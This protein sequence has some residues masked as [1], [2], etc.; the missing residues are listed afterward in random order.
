MSLF[1]HFLCVHQ[2]FQFMWVPFSLEGS[3]NF[4]CCVAFLVTKSLSMGMSINVII[5]LLFSKRFGKG[6]SRHRITLFFTLSPLKMLLHCLLT[7]IV[8]D[9]KSDIIFTFVFWMYYVFSFWLIGH[10]FF[11]YNGLEQFNYSVTRHSFLPVPCAHSSF[12]TLDGWV[13]N[14][15]YD[16]SVS[17][18]VSSVFSFKKFLLVFFETPNT[19]LC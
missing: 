15:H 8:F 10:L 12:V 3:V 19:L 5:Q 1:L 2:E 17:S 14:F 9:E 4:S 16:W 18:W 6:V 11:F 13:Y 7:S